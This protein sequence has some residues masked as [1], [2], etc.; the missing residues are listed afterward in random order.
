MQVKRFT[1]NSYIVE[2]NP[3]N[4][5]QRFTYKQYQRTCDADIEYKE[6]VSRQR[7]NSRIRPG[8]LELLLEQRTLRRFVLH[9]RGSDGDR[10]LVG[11]RSDVRYHPFHALNASIRLDLRGT[12]LRASRCR[13]G[14]SFFALARRSSTHTSRYVR[15]RHFLVLN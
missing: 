12:S 6:P 15:V 4:P 7:T 9:R 3:P 8:N 2:V 10:R 11:G 5:M 1:D 13:T 14:T